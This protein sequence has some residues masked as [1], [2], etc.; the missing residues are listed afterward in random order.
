MADSS[1]SEIP[2]H[3][4]LEIEAVLAPA[5]A[6]AFSEGPRGPE[7]LLMDDPCFVRGKV[8][9]RCARNKTRFGIN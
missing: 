9:E 1:Y 7:W 6:P 2:H 4:L 8:T 5:R 3:L